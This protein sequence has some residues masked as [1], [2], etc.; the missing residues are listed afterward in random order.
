L[1][2]FI[3]LLFASI[4]LAVQLPAIAAPFTVV[5]NGTI[6][7]TIDGVDNPTLTLTRGSTYTFNLTASGHP[8]WIKTAQITGTGSAYNNGVT[9]NGIDSGTITWVVPP[10]APSVLYYNCQFHSPMTGQINITDPVPALTPL[11]TGV[12]GLLLAGGGVLFVRRR[13]AQPPRRSH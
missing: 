4:A 12:L 8:F 11:A 5:N 10:D 13:A 1:R 7:Y 9:N 2:T 3:T 6:A